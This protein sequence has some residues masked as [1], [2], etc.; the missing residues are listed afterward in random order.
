MKKILF[1]FSLA[2]VALSCNNGTTK[3][4]A[5]STDSTAQK[6]SVDLPYKASYSGN[7]TTDVSDADLKMVLTTYK[8]WE[9]GNI[10]DLSKSMGDSVFV[11]FNT[12]DHFNGTN[13]DLMKIWSKTRDSLSS[14]V[15]DME[16]WQKMYEPTKKETA[17][18]T[19]YKETDTYKTGKVDSAYYHD[20]N[21]VKN[22]K[23]TFYSQ[24]KRPAK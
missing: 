18:V 21:A 8:D 24:Y 23:I 20:I 13:A 5:T 2:F 9:N 11:D 7:F 19:W 17:I 16:A 6:S 15:I 12:G 4:E 22:G 14:V 3:T 10:A 1:C